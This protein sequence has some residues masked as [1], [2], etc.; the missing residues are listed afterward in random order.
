MEERLFQKLLSIGYRK[1]LTYGEIRELE[2]L[3]TALAVGGACGLLGFVLFLPG[4]FRREI[5]LLPTAYVALVLVCFH[6]SC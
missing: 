6:F 2:S 5:L 1:D 4:Y 3:N